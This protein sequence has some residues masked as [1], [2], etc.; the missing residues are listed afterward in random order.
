MKTGKKG[1]FQRGTPKS[2]PSDRVFSC[3]C[4]NCNGI[5]FGAVRVSERKFKTI[6][7]RGKTNLVGGYSN[8]Y[9]YYILFLF[10]VLTVGFRPYFLRQITTRA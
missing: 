1:V 9:I 4:N 10:T 5:R 7:K 2:S 6:T 8:Q 3:M